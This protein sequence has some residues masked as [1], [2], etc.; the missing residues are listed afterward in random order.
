VVEIPVCYGDEFGIDLEAVAI[1]HGL[2][3]ERVIELHCAL[4]YHLC[5]L[6]FTPGFPYLG[7]LD[8]RLY[9][10]RKEGPRKLVPAGSVGS[11]D[12]QTGIY[13]IAS[14]GGWHSWGG[15]RAGSSTSG[16]RTRSSLAPG[17]K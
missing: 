4:L 1:Y 10:P 6:G 9:T 7:G 12:R 15:R 17:T 2:P 16:R 13:P 14:P 8:E 11:A 5:M 3:V